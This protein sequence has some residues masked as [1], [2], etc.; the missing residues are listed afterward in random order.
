MTKDDRQFIEYLMERF[1]LQELPVEGG[2]YYRGYLSAESIPAGKLPERYKN[3]HPFGTGIY[4]LL[5]DDPNS[6]S[7]MHVLPTDEIYHFYLGDPVEMLLLYPDGSTH[8]QIL[9]QDLRHGQEVQ[10]L[11]PAGVWQGSHLKPGGSY[12]LLGTT[13]APGYI[14]EDFTLG[15]RADLTRAYPERADLIKTLTRE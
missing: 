13:M 5:V 3:D 8:V 12:A 14:D 4:Y 7:A 1:H 6:F 10:W 11:A 2:V 15:K 9:G